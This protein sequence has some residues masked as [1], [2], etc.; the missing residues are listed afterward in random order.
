[1]AETTASEAPAPLVRALARAAAF[2]TDGSELYALAA[3]RLSSLADVHVAGEFRRQCEARR[4][5]FVRLLVAAGGEPPDPFRRR[6]PATGAWA[7][8]AKAADDRARFAALGEAERLR[9]AEYRA[10]LAR[11]EPG[12]AVRNAFERALFG[13]GARARRMSSRFEESPAPLPPA[14]AA[15]R[16]AAAAR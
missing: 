6:R 7:A 10:A 11:L 5:E 16:D 1:M 4:D 8:L 9:F 3:A 14:R 2:E 12:F 13:A 15:S